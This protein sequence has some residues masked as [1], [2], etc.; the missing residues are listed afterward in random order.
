MVAETH[1]LRDLSQNTEVKERTIRSYV[2][3]GLLDGP[4][5]RGRNA[6]YSG[7]DLVRLQA[8]R[9]LREKHGWQLGE[10]RQW[11]A[12]QSMDVVRALA[13]EGTRVR[14]S[15]DVSVPAG[16][17]GSA[18]EYLDSLGPSLLEGAVTP[19]VAAKPTR[20]ATTRTDS[21]VPGEA[22]TS[23]AKPE[24][25]LGEITRERAA[26]RAQ[27]KKQRSRSTPLWRRIRVNADVEIMMSDAL[28]DKQMQLL[29][30]EARSLRKQLARGR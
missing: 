1:S 23:T 11:L 12:S 20:P 27:P 17:A 4:G 13:G 10:I 2:E 7:D 6:R 16:P 25:T 8:I 24:S 26:A 5:T 9:V 3:Q 19:A 14:Q 28:S 22:Q 18:L 15:R 30:R 29:E 21:A